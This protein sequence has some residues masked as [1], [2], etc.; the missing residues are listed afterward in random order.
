M[1]LAGP[2]ATAVP[3]ARAARRQYGHKR[4]RHLPAGPAR[5]W[6]PPSAAPVA[7]A[8]ALNSTKASPS[9]PAI[10]PDYGSPAPPAP[11]A[12]VRQG[13]HPPPG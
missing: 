6:S 12:P 2:Q 4:C 1:R 10:R 11:A 5:H 3:A 8:R 9:H 7:R 13:H